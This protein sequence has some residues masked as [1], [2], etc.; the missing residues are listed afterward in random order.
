MEVDVLPENLSKAATLL[1]RVTPGRT[2]LPILADLLLET[3]QGRLAVTA[4]DLELCATIHVGAQVHTEGA[5]TLPAKTLAKI[6]AKLPDD[7]L[8]IHANTRTATLDQNGRSITLEGNDAADFPPVPKHGGEAGR[9][10]TGDFLEA[11]ASVAFCAS[12]DDDRPALHAVYIEAEGDQL[13]LTATDGFRLASFH[14]NYQG[15]PFTSLAPI[16]SLTKF[17]KLLKATHTFDDLRISPTDK[18]LHLEHGNLEAT[19]QPVLATFPDYTQIVPDHHNARLTLVRTALMRELALCLTL[20]SN[21]SR[22]VRLQPN[23]DKLSLSGRSEGDGTYEATLDLKAEGQADIKGAYNAQQ[24]HD[25]LTAMT[26][27][28]VTIDLIDEAHPAVLY[29]CEAGTYVL[30]PMTVKW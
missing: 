19:I 16:N 30:M 1:A 10:E 27:D 3:R 9:V 14:L 8:R 22:I 25:V 11:L 20:I 15:K 12:S 13:T 7:K 5:I 28:T 21:S 2:S 29:D 6:A 18:A 24:L 26:Q 23:G 17:A 4:T